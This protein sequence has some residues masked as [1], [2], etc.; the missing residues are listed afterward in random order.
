MFGCFYH[1]PDPVGMLRK[2]NAS[3]KPK[4]KLLL[5]VMIEGDEDMLFQKKYAN[6]K[7]VYFLP[8]ATAEHWLKR[9]GFIILRF[10]SMNLFVNEQE[11]LRGR[12]PSYKKR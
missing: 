11:G 6:M 7:G 4:G 9:S 10:S 12:C 3:L 8:T 1:T 2:I 5:I